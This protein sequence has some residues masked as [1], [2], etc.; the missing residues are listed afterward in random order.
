ML[1]RTLKPRLVSVSGAAEQYTSCSGGATAAEPEPPLL[2][3]LCMSLPLVSCMAAVM[4]QVAVMQEKAKRL[5][6]AIVSYHKHLRCMA[7]FLFSRGAAAAVFL[8]LGVSHIRRTGRP[9]CC[10]V[11]LQNSH[12]AR[13]ATLL[14][15]V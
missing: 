9:H 2:P 13:S 5:R 4:L 14:A 15:G 3:T 10:F 8:D 12:F 6:L 11:P 7:I 1:P